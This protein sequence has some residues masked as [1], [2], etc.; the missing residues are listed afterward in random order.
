MTTIGARLAAVREEAGHSL[1]ALSERT[2]IREA[3]LAAMEQDRF[4]EC[5]GAFYVRGHIRAICRDLGADPE[6]LLTRFDNEY[7]EARPEPLLT[8]PVTRPGE[9][10]RHVVA[11]SLRE[12]LR[13]PWPRRA[14]DPGEAGPETET[15][16]PG[17][18]EVA[19]EV[20]APVA[21]ARVPRPRTAPAA[22]SGAERQGEPGTAL[23][24]TLAEVAHRP[25]PLVAAGAI[26]VAGVATVFQMWSADGALSAATRSGPQP[27]PAGQSGPA[28]PGPEGA[29]DP[30]AV[31]G[32]GGR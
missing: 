21:P 30:A 5:G 13:W 16:A 14:E 23:A 32:E 8:D 27:Q 18:T 6:P 15:E 25:W 24:G 9:P 28:D 22:E 31:Q 3:I 19:E 17:A 29:A 10:R 12:R 7:T 4:D 11:I 1:V 26:M 2:R 20:R